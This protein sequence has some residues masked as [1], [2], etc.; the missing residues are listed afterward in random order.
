MT[1]Y[2]EPGTSHNF[3]TINNEVAPF[4]NINF[5][6]AIASAIDKDAVVPGGF[7][8]R[9]NAGERHGSRLL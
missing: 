7:K 9:R 1:L 5:R 8:R 2:S 6:K 4:D 3:L